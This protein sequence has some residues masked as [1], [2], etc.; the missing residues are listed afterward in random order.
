MTDVQ[1]DG[2]VTI[3]Q[4]LPFSCVLETAPQCGDARVGLRAAPTTVCVDVYPCGVRFDDCI[5]RS[6]PCR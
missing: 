1:C 6:R 4:S 3:Y 5:W 2:R